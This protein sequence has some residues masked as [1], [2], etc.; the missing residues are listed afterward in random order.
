MTSRPTAKNPYVE[1]AKA[2]FPYQRMH[3]EEIPPHRAPVV[4]DQ[5]QTV[6]KRSFTDRGPQPRQV[7]QFTVGEKNA[8]G[9]SRAYHKLTLD[10]LRIG[11]MQ[12][13][14]ADG[15][16]SWGT[17]YG[18]A[19]GLPNQND[20][21]Q[22]HNAPRGGIAPRMPYSEVER[23]FGSLDST[24]TM[25]GADGGRFDTRSEYQQHFAE[26]GAAARVRREPEFTLKFSND[27]GSDTKASKVPP[28]ML[29]ATHFDF[30]TYAGKRFETTTYDAHGVAPVLDPKQ[31]AAGRGSARRRWSAASGSRSRRRTTTLSP[32][33]TGWADGSTPRR[34]TPRA[35]RSASSSSRRSIPRCAAPLARARRLTLSRGSNGQGLGG[36]TLDTYISSPS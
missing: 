2:E 18:Q 9:T 3:R 35:R 25:P 1:L 26:P 12:L 11:Q 19:F 8:L 6:H 21:F 15:K 7:P 4:D 14:P 23:N 29:N 34:P 33:G 5:Y 10:E 17:T 31:D 32:R 27:I 30:G 16:P 36:D 28:T 24:G 22:G 20:R 13:T